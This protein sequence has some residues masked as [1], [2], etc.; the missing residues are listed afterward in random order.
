[1]TTSD[2]AI[3]PFLNF[4]RSKSI[5]NYWLMTD[6]KKVYNFTFVYTTISIGYTNM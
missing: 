1:M 6:L 2:L 4:L 3:I 5:K